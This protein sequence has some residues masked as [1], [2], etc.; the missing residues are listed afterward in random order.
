MQ[1]KLYIPFICIITSTSSN[2]IDLK[3]KLNVRTTSDLFFKAA[4]N[5]TALIT[6]KHIPCGTLIT[7][8]STENYMEPLNKLLSDKNCYNFN[9]RS[10]R[11]Q[12]WLIRSDFYITSVKNFFQF[13]LNFNNLSTNTAWNPR[14]QFIILIY[15]LKTSEY[16]EVFKLLFKLNIFNIIL[17]TKSDIGNL[18]I[19]TY[20]PFDNNACGRSFGEII[21]IKNCEDVDNIRTNYDYLEVKYRNC[22]ITIAGSEDVPNFIYATNKEYS[23]LQK[24][25]QGLEQYMLANFAIRENITLEYILVGTELGYGVVLP[26][27]TASGSLSY[28]QNNTVSIVTGGY[29]LML[30]RVQLFD[31]IWGYNTATFLL[32]TPAQGE[33]HWTKF[34]QQFSGTTWFLIALCYFVITILTIFTRL[35]FMELYDAKRMALILWGY[36]FGNTN[37][38]LIRSRKLRTIVIIWIWFIFFIN[39]F[40]STAFYKLLTTKSIEKLM[41]AKNSLDSLP[42]KPCISDNTRI[43][44]KYEYNV[45]LPGKP[46]DRCKNISR[47]LDTVANGNQFYAIE[48]DY[49]YNIREFKYIDDKGHRKLDK[50][51]YS[52]NIM[53]AIY[54]T[55]GFPLREKLQR[56]AHYHMEAGLLKNQA[57]LINHRYN[58]FNKHYSHSFEKLCLSDVRIPYMILFV[59]YIISLI[60]FIIEIKNYNKN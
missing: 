6:Y 60:C 20:S 12:D 14:A 46:I 22:T 48:L 39:S 24:N 50:F 2:Q 3:N 28:L 25:N 47:S 56:Y 29:L 17:L 10:F 58:M 23:Y 27:W 35:Y 19:N 4:T 8:I 18:K 11:R 36:I 49:S 41:Y 21:N 7:L 44:F 38:K 5:C 32:F 54:M 9:T 31:C 37:E 55:R 40:Y 34:Y 13:Y 52:N 16:N 30:N 33:I 57:E 53:S 45:T 1:F 26:N 59:G 42:L 51:Q 43:F 15:E